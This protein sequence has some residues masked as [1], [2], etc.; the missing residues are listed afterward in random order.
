MSPAASAWGLL[1]SDGLILN[2]KGMNDTIRFLDEVKDRLEFVPYDLIYQSIADMK[3]KFVPTALLK[4]GWYIDRVRVHKNINEIFT[5]EH[6]VSYIHDQDI[7][8]NFVT[9]GRANKKKQAVFYGAVE[10]EEIRHPRVVAYFETSDLLKELDQQENAV[11]LF[12]V[13]RWEILEDIEILEMIFSDEALKKSSSTRT[14]LEHQL[15]NYKDSP[16]A[17]EYEEQG[18]FF[19]N[20]F[21]RNDVKKGQEYKYKITAAYANYIW[22]NPKL[23]GITYPSVQSDY[24]GQNVALL[25]EI[26]DKYLK[27]EFVGI[28]KFERKAGQNLPVDSIKVAT[29]LGKENM[30]F[31][32]VDYVG[33]EH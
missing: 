27:L 8:D 1:F 20:E 25:P 11:E 22:E 12:T 9:F 13:S 7:L 16:L 19:S 14:S 10:T 30:E 4:K 2:K 33:S 18:R 24:K 26:V 29:D 5:N 28:F 21:A 31:K 23:K 3:D 15:N 32:W 17:K 6:Q